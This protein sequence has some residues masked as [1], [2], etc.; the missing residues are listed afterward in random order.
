MNIQ[1]LDYSVDL[2]AALLWQYDDAEALQ[3]LLTRK[4]AWYDANHR[5]YWTNWVRDVFDLRTAN[6]FGLAVW[7]IILRM[8]L[9]AL[10]PDQSAKPTWGLG[11]D[12][13]NYTNGNFAPGAAASALSVAQRRLMLRLRYFQLMT[14]G[15]VTEVNAFLATVFG[16]GQVYATMPDPMHVHYVFT[17]PISSAVQLVLQEFD[18][19][20]R[21][22]GVNATFGT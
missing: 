19:L 17:A 21:P 2:L 12:D 11:P 3:L 22:A 1:A 15:A 6:E 20:P 5:D 7:A 13:V 18:V 4:Q 16:P 10:P 8:P 14:R 9:V